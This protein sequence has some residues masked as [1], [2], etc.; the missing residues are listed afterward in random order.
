MYVY[1]YVYMYH[2]Y[3]SPILFLWRILIHWPA[4][5]VYSL[6]PCHQPTYHLFQEAFWSILSWNTCLT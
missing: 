6:F 3:V 4:P 5:S 2:I 1:M